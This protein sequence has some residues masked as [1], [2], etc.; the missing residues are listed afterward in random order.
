MHTFK[1]IDG[2]EIKIGNMIVYSS[3]RGLVVA[4]VVGFTHKLH[5]SETVISTMQVRRM[6]RYPDTRLAYSKT[7]LTPKAQIVMLD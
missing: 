2:K 5:W 7:T 3:R 4:K 1:T 6:N